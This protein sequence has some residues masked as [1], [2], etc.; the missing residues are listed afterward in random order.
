[1]RVVQANIRDGYGWVL[2]MDLEAFFDRVNHD[3]LMARLKLRS[4]DSDLL[5][6]IN[7]YLKAGVQLEMG[8][9]PTTMGVPQGG[10]P[11]GVS[12]SRLDSSC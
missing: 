12:L 2:D 6:L 7:R 8:T 11:R 5:R 10:A 9:Q 1:M 3:R 4:H